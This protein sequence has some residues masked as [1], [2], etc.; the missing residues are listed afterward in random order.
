M[1]LKWKLLSLI[2]IQICILF[3][4]RLNEICPQKL[5]LN[6]ENSQIWWLWFKKSYKISKH[7]MNML[8][9]IWKYSGFIWLGSTGFAC[10]MCASAHNY[11]YQMDSNQKIENVDFCQ[12]T[13]WVWFFGGKSLFG[14]SSTKTY[15]KYMYIFEQR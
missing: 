5:T 14:P 9:E 15:S 7:L 10:T 3:L 13:I 2:D 12:L 8:I 11:L 6:F 1:N 4:E